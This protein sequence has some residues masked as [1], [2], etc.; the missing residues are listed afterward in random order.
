MVHGR[1]RG[2]LPA[3]YGCSTRPRYWF[4]LPLAAGRRNH[5]PERGDRNAISGLKSSLTVGQLRP[6]MRRAK[7]V[8][9]RAITE[10]MGTAAM[11]KSQDVV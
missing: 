11:V 1:V 10:H 5:S 2:G 7:V 4:K 8:G 9:N 3:L 6:D